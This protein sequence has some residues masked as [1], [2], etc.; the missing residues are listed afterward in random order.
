MPIVPYQQHGGG[1]APL[2][3][4]LSS[5][6][7]TPPTSDVFPEYAPISIP[8]VRENAP[9]FAPDASHASSRPSIDIVVDHPS[10]QHSLEQTPVKSLI[11]VD[12]SVE[13][14]HQMKGRK[15]AIA[16]AGTL[17]SLTI[18]SQIYQ[19]VLFPHITPASERADE[20][21]WVASSRSWLDRRVCNWFGLC[22]L[23]HLN[24]AAWIS[25]DGPKRQRTH[26]SGD[27][28][29][30]DLSKFWKD[31]NATTNPQDWS[32]DERRAREIPQY[33]LD[34][35]PYIYLYSGEEFWPCDMAE[36]LIHTTPHLN[37]T[38]LQAA[39]DHPNLT[40]L[41][42]LNK[43]GPFVYLQSD[44]NVEDR[45]E[46]LGGKTNIP[47][48]PDDSD[49]DSDTEWPGEGDSDE[50]PPKDVDGEDSSW[51][52]VGDGDTLERGGVRPPP[53]ATTSPVAVPS[54]TPEG[55]EFVHNPDDDWR[56]ELTRRKL[57]RKLGKK[58][59][60]GRSDAPAVLVVV[61]KDEGVV[62]AFFFFFYSYNLGNKVFNVRFGNHV[63]DW[64]HT[65]VR[66]QNGV[67]KAVFFSEHAYG[68]AYTYEAL[69][70][71]GKRVCKKK[72][73]VDE[74]LTWAS[75]WDTLLQGPTPC[76][77]YPEP[78]HMCYQVVFFTTKRT[79]DRFGIHS[80]TCTLIRTIIGV[81]HY[82][83]RISHQRHPL[84]GFTSPAT[85]ETSSTR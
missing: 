68:E 7:S 34:Y 42:D 82:A 59:V 33:V 22:G 19:R 72:H 64:E 84:G 27:W 3:G 61:E 12:E 15:P 77:L 6:P 78:T 70:K 41:V 58:V 76:M 54:N 35:A 36:H 56:L 37:Y 52:S 55:E 48:T 24:K 45:P 53:G 1:Q 40:N 67:P 81:I 26:S 62:D 66:F 14:D 71:I 23:A 44:D 83:V 17:L 32:D 13:S 73:L 60:G 16:A 4:F 11:P 49:P 10:N 57:G 46:W 25:T 43:W 21:D 65:L 31:V 29:K 80:S 5:T 47:N 2:R 79:V 39:S 50:G 75:P 51:W 20:R 30:T 18:F 69:E 28:E 8:P 74:P 85:G 63:G 9:Y 38:P